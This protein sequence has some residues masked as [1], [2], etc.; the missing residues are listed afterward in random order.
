MSCHFQSYG[1][2]CACDPNLSQEYG[3]FDPNN[4]G[5]Y[6]NAHQAYGGGLDSHSNVHHS[7]GEDIN[8]HSNAYQSFSDGTNYHANAC[9]SFGDG[10]SS[11]GHPSFGQ[12]FAQSPYSPYG[13]PYAYPQR[14]QDFDSCGGGCCTDDMASTDYY[15]PGYY[16]YL[17]PPVMVETVENVEEFTTKRE[18]RPM[19]GTKTRGPRKRAGGRR[20]RGYYGSYG[21]G[22]CSMM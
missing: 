1:A 19:A 20:G 22:G 9:H 11:Y 21:M 15:M 2:S 10:T 12:D 14:F 4:T 7:Y 6:S 17:W 3:S 16:E 13:Y 8:C 5:C 18:F